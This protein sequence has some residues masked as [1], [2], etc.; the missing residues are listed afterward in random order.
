MT[1]V[2]A[3]P[4]WPAPAGEASIPSWP[5]FWQRVRNA[6]DRV[7]AYS[8][9]HWIRTEAGDRFEVHNA[10]QLRET[11]CRENLTPYVR[12]EDFDAWAPSFY[13]SGECLWNP[14]HSQISGFRF[15]LSRKVHYVYRASVWCL[16]G[17]SDLDRL[18]RFLDDMALGDC[19]TPGALGFRLMGRLF[20]RNQRLRRPTW[21]AWHDMHA[22][23]QG[24]RT[25]LLDSQGEYPELTEI[26][27][28]SAYAHALAEDAPA[29]TCI[30]LFCEEDGNECAWTYGLYRWSI[31]P[32]LEL[33]AERLGSRLPGHRLRW[34][35]DR[36]IEYEGW[37]TGAEVAAARDAGYL[38]TF[39]RGWGYTETTTAFAQWANWIDSARR[40]Y[41]SLG[42]DLEETWCKLAT[43]AAIGRF[44][45][46]RANF[47]VT[48]SAYENSRLG[49]AP[50]GYADS[51][52]FGIGPDAI[53]VQ[54]VIPRRERNYLLPQLAIHVHAVTRMRMDA[55]IPGWGRAAVM[56]NIDAWYVALGEDG[57]MRVL[58]DLQQPSWAWKIKGLTP[59]KIGGNIRVQAAGWVE[60]G[61][62]TKKPGVKR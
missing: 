3:L 39:V 30:K 10:I 15:K 43:V 47:I 32:D 22:N 25:Q 19:P 41:Q 34:H 26:D 36:G 50:E 29:G 6:P 40:H 2:D 16:S 24:G 31:P 9:A 38:C 52:T 62:L 33:D 61:N 60:A 59:R 5:Q 48:T 55:L 13:S 49:A 18:R 12:D 14:A 28:N 44:G 42:A 4:D 1:A 37:Y 46:D 57:A 54:R 53:S 35:H 7:L 23:L 58:F 56:R 17:A 20:P 27:L 45:M 21:P 11:V 8:S 51:K